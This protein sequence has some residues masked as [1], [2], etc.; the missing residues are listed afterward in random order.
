M[1]FISY[2]S[3]CYIN[4]FVQA[5]VEDYSIPAGVPNGSAVTGALPDILVCQ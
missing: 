3:I 4:Y 5:E 1:C 2:M